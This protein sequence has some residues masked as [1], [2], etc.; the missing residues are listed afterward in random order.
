MQ[1]CKLYAAGLCLL[2]AALLC[3][4][5][6]TNRPFHD[7]P[8]QLNAEACGRRA[9]ALLDADGNGRLEGKEL[10]K[11][12]GL[13][14][15]LSR[16]DS[17]GLGYV[18]ADAIAK[19]IKQWQESKI[20]RMRVTCSVMHNGKPL[21]GALVKFI[22]EEFL[23]DMMM[24]ASGVTD[25]KG[26]AKISVMLGSENFKGVPPGFYRVEISKSGLNISE[27]YNSA[28]VLGADVPIDVDEPRT[29]MKFDLEF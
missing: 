15:A 6:C 29:V 5:S 13:K 25:E 17:D 21:D 16:L 27:K 18:T 1:G 3:C 7:P 8:P 14:A 10:D 11:C 2:S 4:L 28:T 22:P 20:G 19:R 12:P 9:I 23:G 26:I 24:N